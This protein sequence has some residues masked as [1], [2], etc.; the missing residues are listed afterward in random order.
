MPWFGLLLLWY[1]GMSL[2]AGLMHAADKRKARRGARRISERNLHLA[3]LAGGWPGA[4]LA[5]R[6]LRHKTA[7]VSYRLKS[8]A[9][10]LAHL[11]AWIAATWLF[12]IE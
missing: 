1:A 2:V 11:T 3:E 9:I 6:L 12:F 5:R 4:W 10:A 8:A 7:K